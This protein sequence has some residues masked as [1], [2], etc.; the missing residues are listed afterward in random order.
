MQIVD[1]G[2]LLLSI[3][4]VL[5][6]VKQA[7]LRRR[8]LALNL[9][10]FGFFIHFIVSLLRWQ[11]APWYLALIVMGVVEIVARLRL[12]P[13]SKRWRI[14]FIG[15]TMSSVLANAAFPIIAMPNASGPYAIG[16]SSQLIVN[17]NRIE[18]YGALRG[19]PRTFKVQ[20]WYPAQST[21]GFEQTK[22][23]ADGLVVP[24]ALTRDWSL[25]FFVLDHISAY[26]SSA[27]LNAPLSTQQGTYPVVI[28]S[29]G[30]SSKRTLHTDLAEE[31]ASQGYF[32]VGMEHTYG[33]L[34]TV[35]GNEEADV[36]YLD[37][38]ALP[39]RAVT[40]NY[41]EFANLLVETYASDI[42]AAIDTLEALNQASGA[43]NQRLDLSSIQVVG[44]STGGGAA[45]KAAIDDPRITSVLGMDAWVEP[46]TASDLSAGLSTRALYLR[47]NG[48]ETG[49]NNE[50]LYQLL[51]T[52]SN[53]SPL[54]QIDG[55][56]HYDFAMVYMY[57][58]LTR[59]LGITGSLEFGYLNTML[60]TLVLEFLAA[61]GEYQID[62]NQWSEVRE[63]RLS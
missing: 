43:L 48:W 27:Y 46:L 9:L 15:L 50:Y 61:D 19:Q 25:P 38:D 57:T 12:K 32:V 54:Y 41:L 14:V 24:R 2:V 23:I 30:W 55:T 58:P 37:Y 39:R 40:P 5:Y 42:I 17:P 3:P 29:H 33:S 62:T 1:Y 11:F 10:F 21:D 28:I 51:Q 16:T 22:W 26:R 60:D 59:V 52:S 36:Q 20:Y 44:H 4:V 47:S 18:E 53:A 63:I 49:E 7:E 31:L 6:W 45:V 34:A 13:P 35:L 8:T 56:T